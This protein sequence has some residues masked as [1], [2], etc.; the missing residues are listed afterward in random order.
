MSGEGSSSQNGLRGHPEI[1][2]HQDIP[3]SRSNIFLAYLLDSPCYCLGAV[4]LQL[5]QGRLSA[6][7]LETVTLIP[8]RVPIGRTL[9]TFVA[10][11][12]ATRKG[13]NIAVCEIR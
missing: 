8:T 2:L 3:N 1:L 6:M 11:W 10:R 4:K 12:R 5:Q 7:P 9:P 13:I